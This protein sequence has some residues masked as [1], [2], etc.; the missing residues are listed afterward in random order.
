MGSIMANKI[1]RE[2]DRRVIKTEAAI[3]E[4]FVKLA[5]ERD[6]K[7]ITISALAAEAN[8]DRKTFYLHYPSIDALMKSLA[9]EE[10]KRMAHEL[11]CAARQNCDSLD[12]NDL[13]SE[14]HRITDEHVDFSNATG[15]RDIAP[16]VPIDDLLAYLEE[17]LTEEILSMC[18][19]DDPKHKLYVSYGVTCYVA[20]V[21]A[22]YKRWA[23]EQ[24]EESLEDISNYL[25]TGSI[26]ASSTKLKTMQANS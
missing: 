25:K 15:A 14:I 8:I 19:I 12:P 7:K 22:V 13:M 1:K 2:S 3:K 9:K 11:K 26:C 16:Y 4:A 21:M 18:D 24:P 17:P 10:A 6:F 20:G 5:A 23:L